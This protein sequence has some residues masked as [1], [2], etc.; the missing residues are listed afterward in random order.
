MPAFVAAKKNSSKN[1][2]RT[3]ML[4]AMRDMAPADPVAP[5]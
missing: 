3:A 1:L 2:V 4:S 5:S